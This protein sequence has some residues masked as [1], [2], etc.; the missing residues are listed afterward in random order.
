M[1]LCSK[2]PCLGW[3]S[4]DFLEGFF[5]Q[6]CLLDQRKHTC[7]S[8]K[9]SMKLVRLVA[10]TLLKYQSNE[11]AYAGL[12]RFRNINFVL[13]TGLS[14]QSLGIYLYPGNPVTKLRHRRDPYHIFLSPSKQKTNSHFYTFVE[15]DN[16]L[17]IRAF[18]LE[19]ANSMP[20]KQ[21]SCYYK[22]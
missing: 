3:R 6:K 11:L 9:I 19:I 21:R 14:S 22:F 8:S 12:C 1:V 10:E 17:N 2:L 16:G 7:S 20:E 13:R 4:A 5:Q 15:I 18:E